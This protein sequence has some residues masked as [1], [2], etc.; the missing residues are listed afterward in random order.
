MQVV[1]SVRGRFHAYALAKQLQDRAHLQALMTSYPYWYVKRF[2]IQKAFLRTFPVYGVLPRIWQKLPRVL[3]QRLDLQ[4]VWQRRFDHQVAKCLPDGMDLFVG[5][6]SGCLESI[7]VARALGARTVVERGSTHIEYQNR[8]LTTLYAEAGIPVS[9]AVNAEIMARELAEYECAD[10]IAVPTHFV[11]QTFTDAGVAS[12]KII[13]VP[14]GVDLKYFFPF[15]KQDNRFRVIFSGYACLRKG[16]HLLLEAFSALKLKHAELWFIGRIAPELQPYFG[17]YQADNIIYKGFFPEQALAALYS[18]GSVFCLPSYEE[19]LAMV[20]PQAM[21]C[22]LPVIATHA[23]GAG[24]LFGQNDLGFLI[25]SGNL[26][27]LKEALLWCY[28]HPSDCEAKGNVALETATQWDWNRYGEQVVAQ[29]HAVCAS[30][31]K[32]L[33]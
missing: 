22:G 15:P 16:A 26:S 27:A 11:K 32:H 2:G 21:A 18:Q 8:V 33:V 17:R 14:Y 23:S 1:I 24:E 19:G 7:Q 9:D 3:Q 20:I 10:R 5:W 13:V 29:Y 12:E 6:S 25:E 30:T 4:A 28:E 31:T